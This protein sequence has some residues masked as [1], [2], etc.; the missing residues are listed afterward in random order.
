MVLGQNMR[1]LISSWTLMPGL[2]LLLTAFSDK[3]GLAS[4]IGSRSGVEPADACADLA[5]GQYTGSG[6]TF[7]DCLNVWKDFNDIVWAPFHPRMHDADL[8][9]DTAEEL[10][11]AGSPCLVGT[12]PHSDGAGSTTIR[13]LMTWIFSREMGCDW[14]TPDWGKKFVDGGNGTAVMY[15]HRAGTTAEMDLSKTKA[16]RI[17]LRRCA[18]VDWLSYFQFDV[19]SVPSPVQEKL[20]V[21]KNRSFTQSI[22]EIQTKLRQ[23]DLKRQR[24]DRVFFSV[25]LML[26]SYH[27]VN[28]GSWDGKKRDIVRQV[29]QEARSNFHRHPRPWY[30][31]NPRCHF[32]DNRFNFAVHIRMGDRRA[33]Y[34]GNPQY[35]RNVEL[36]TETVT[37]E[38]RRRGLPEPMFHLFS[39]TLNP[40]P[41]AVTG[42]FDEFPTWPIELEQIAECLAATTPSECPEKQAGG[43]FCAPKRSGIFRVRDK[44]FVLHVGSDVQNE[45]SCMIQA[46]GIVM[47]CSTFGQIAGLLTRGIS[48][49]STRCNGDATPTQYRSIPP[50]AIAERGHLWVPVEGSWHDP[51]L[52]S[53]SIFRAALDSL[54]AVKGRL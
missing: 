33:Y 37:D 10:R 19:P 46:D 23:T 51:I 20:M 9:I 6:W 41:S 21:P 13:H 47:G 24:L 18:V 8:W 14:V 44:S 2:L 17:A 12:N 48:F 54:L 25:D 45:M 30:D 7:E 36:I 53:T 3:S 26:A 22:L 29:L 16:E 42:L 15:C 38:F 35:F 50:L 40:C 52:S 34:D 11:L 49:F 39:E 28:V 4:V 43:N 32:E 27:L 31:E 5:P 1:V